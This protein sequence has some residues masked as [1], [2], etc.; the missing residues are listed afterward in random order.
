RR[1]RESGPVGVSGSGLVSLRLPRRQ[2]A[3]LYGPTVG[4][5]VRLADTD[6]LIEVE[7][8]LTVYRDEAKFCGGKVI[9]DGIGPS[10]HATAGDGVLDL[11]ITMGLGL[12]HWCIVKADLGVLGGRIVGVGKAGKPDI[13][14]GV[15]P[16]MIV[17]ASTE[18][19]AGEGRIVTAGGIDSHIHFI[20]PQ[21]VDEALS[22]G[23]AAPTP[24]GAGPPPRPNP[25]PTPP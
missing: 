10:A 3:D 19:I 9:R 21:L 25:P 6:I 5:R 18:V 7:Q 4:D 17:G 13:Q 14:P 20:C 23:L 2:Y 16:G 24:A 8:D 15:A 12:D 1:R 22:A 11:V